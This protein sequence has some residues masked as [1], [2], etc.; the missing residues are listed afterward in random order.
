M[1]APERF[2]YDDELVDMVRPVHPRATRRMMK[3]L[4][5]IGALTGEWDGPWVLRARHDETVAYTE[6]MP[7]YRYRVTETGQMQLRAI[8][9]PDGPSR[10][11]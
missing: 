6:R 4:C 7:R 9:G 3:R 8:L 5:D 1:A 10:D 2:H 11:T